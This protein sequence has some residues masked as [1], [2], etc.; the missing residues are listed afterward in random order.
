MRIIIYR[1]D[2]YE[3]PAVLGAVGRLSR[4]TAPVRDKNPKGAG[5]KDCQDHS[6]PDT[7]EPSDAFCQSRQRGIRGARA[8]VLGMVRDALWAAAQ[9]PGSADPSFSRL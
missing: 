9:K 7:P 4:R 6:L 1:W 2:S 8:S 3:S 5:T